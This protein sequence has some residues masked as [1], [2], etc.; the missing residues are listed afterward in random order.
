MGK[1]ANFFN[2]QKI[3]L[4]IQQKQ[5]MLA[6]DKEFETLESKVTVLQA[7]KLNLEA[8]VNPLKR[9]IERLQN[10]VKETDSQ[11]HLRL[12]EFAEKIL[13]A[14]AN[15]QQDRERIFASLN[16]AKI[17]G[18]YLFDILYERNFVSNEFTV[19]SATPLGRAYLVENNLV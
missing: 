12:A 13:L 8:Q 7:E 3:A 6:L 14:V 11:D 2:A 4:A 1:V 15:G 17:I 19:L 9:E 5:Q 16:I 10:Q 18:D